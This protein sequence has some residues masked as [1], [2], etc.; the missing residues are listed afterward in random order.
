MGLEVALIASV[1]GTAYSVSQQRKASKAQRA[2]SIA[3]Q[4]QQSLKAARSRRIAFRELQ[5]KRAQAQAT[6]AAL[7]ASGGSGAAG[8]LSSL[9]S[10]Y[11][12]NLGYGS[13]M[14]N[15]SKEITSFN[16]LAQQSLSN[17]QSGAAVAGLGLGVMQNPTA[18]TSVKDTIFGKD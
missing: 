11:G 3:S 12:A 9:V 18:F 15:L 4:R 8:G 5:R 17:A 2:A 7:G 14:T 10:Q 13:A 16:S 1:A 6:A